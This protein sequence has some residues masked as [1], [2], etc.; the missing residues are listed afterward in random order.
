MNTLITGASDGIGLEMAK[1]LHKKGHKIYVVAR[2]LEKLE[3]NFSNFD[4]CVI[5]PTDLS[6]QENCIKLYNDLK[7]ENIEILINNAGVGVLGEFSKTKLDDELNM[8]DLNI[9]AVHILTKLFLND[10]LIKDRGYILNICSIG[11]FFQSPMLASYYASKSY[12]LNLT[13]SIKEEIK[14]SNVY[15]G[16]FCP[17]TINTNFH[18]NAGSNVEY[19]KGISPKKAGTYAINQMFKKKTIII[20][21]FFVKLV[22]LIVRITPTSIILKISKMINSKK[23]EQ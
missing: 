6:N 21:S 7:N 14:N 22:P 4:N 1:I 2:N 12:V 17:A 13:L 18:K 9:K 20:P 11:A 3:R 8:I 23:I 5:M 15:I 16:A 19:E 10:F